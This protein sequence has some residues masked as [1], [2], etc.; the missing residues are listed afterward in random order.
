M[1][2]GYK[3]GWVG[4]DP[5]RCSKGVWGSAVSSPDPQKLFKFRY[6]TVMNFVDFSSPI[7]RIEKAISINNDMYSTIL[8]SIAHSDITMH[9]S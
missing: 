2:G 8:P 1:G 9:M 7:Q 3:R 5:S 6:R 4:V